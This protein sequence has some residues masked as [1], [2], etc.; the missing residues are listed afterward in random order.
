MGWPYWAGIVVVGGVI[1]A[2]DYDMLREAGV[3]AIFGPGTNLVDAAG[4]VN[5]PTAPVIYT[6]SNQ[7]DHSRLAAAST[8][9]PRGGGIPTPRGRRG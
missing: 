4:E 7:S 9:R 6:R 5:V 8:R 1:P 3:Q 2:Q